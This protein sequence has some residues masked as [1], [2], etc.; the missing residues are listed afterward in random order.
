MRRGRKAE[1]AA[2]RRAREA[3]TLEIVSRF[4]CELQALFDHDCDGPMDACHVID[5][6]FL[7]QM[8]K[9]ERDAIGGPLFYSDEE[10]LPIVW[11]VR[12]GLSGCRAGHTRFDRP[13]RP[14]TYAQLPPAVI[15]FAMDYGIEHRL[16]EMY[17]R[18]AIA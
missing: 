9:K 10:L 13:P 2:D 4:C 11:D 5:K 8:P 14:V 15:E 7:K 1:S 6:Q 18:T 12:N 17:P 16:E 3:W